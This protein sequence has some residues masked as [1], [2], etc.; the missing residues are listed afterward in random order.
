KARSDLD[1]AQK[2]ATKNTLCVQAG[3]DLTAAA[4]KQDSDGTTRALGAI[5]TACGGIPSPSR[6]PQA[7]APEPADGQA[8]AYALEPTFAA[9]VCPL[10]SMAA[11]NARTTERVLPACPGV[12]HRRNPHA[13]RSQK[14]QPW[15]S[16]QA[17]S[18]SRL[19]RSSPSLSTSGSAGS[20]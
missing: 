14:G 4:L 17:S 18:C 5:F 3:K 8:R 7:K 15:V 10:W 11:R 16:G 9:H 20:T 6:R 13:G 19:A 1:A 12:L 2:E